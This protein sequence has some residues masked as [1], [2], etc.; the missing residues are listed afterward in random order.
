[1]YK[2]PGAFTKFSNRLVTKLAAFG[3]TPA[4]TVAIE[5]RGRKSGQRRVAAVNSVEVAGQRYLV[6]TRGEAEWVRNVRAANGEAAI[7]RRG[8]R[9]VRLA[10]LPVEQR[11][12]II[13][14]YLKENAMTTKSYFGIEPNSPIEEFQRIAP[15]HPVFRIIEAS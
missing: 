10:E 4:K 8:T 7:K 12:P 1:M 3:L 5:V 13:Q 2:R 14:A 6:S 11:A 9:P 15:Q